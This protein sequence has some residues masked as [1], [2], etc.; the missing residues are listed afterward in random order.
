MLL[1]ETGTFKINNTKWSVT[2]IK[3]HTLLDM[4][5]STLNWYSIGKVIPWTWQ[6]GLKRISFS[7]SPSQKEY[8]LNLDES[9]ESPTNLMSHNRD[10][11]GSNKRYDSISLHKLSMALIKVFK[12]E[13]YVL[14]SLAFNSNNTIAKFLEIQ[15]LGLIKKID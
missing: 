13:K 6:H 7:Y 5:S 1:M 15:N 9:N 12:H 3:P 8:V 10:I 2:K 11:R 14:F 4:Y